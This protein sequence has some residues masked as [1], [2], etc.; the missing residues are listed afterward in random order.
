MDVLGVVVVL[1][2]T[3]PLEV[4]VAKGEE[5]KDITAVA[6]VVWDTLLVMEV[7]GVEVGLRV[8]STPGE[9]LPAPGDT[10]GLAEALGHCVAAVDGV[11]VALMDGEGVVDGEASWLR[12]PLRVMLA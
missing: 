7:L 2:L 5:V 6:E 10:L 12:A 8:A 9:A 1:L 4:G 11:A 3:H